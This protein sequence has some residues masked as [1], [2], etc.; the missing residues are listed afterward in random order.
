MQRGGKMNETNG[1]YY[2]GLEI[3]TCDFSRS[4]WDTS[5][6]E[7]VRR[8]YLLSDFAD[9]WHVQDSAMPHPPTIYNMGNN[10]FFFVLFF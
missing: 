7:G 5:G 6:H 3:K 10:C 9:I 4:Q 2:S 8:E 1:L